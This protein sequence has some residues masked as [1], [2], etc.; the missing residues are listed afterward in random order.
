MSGIREAVSA[1]VRDLTGAKDI[2][3]YGGKSLVAEVTAMIENEIKAERE[4][5][6]LVCE[7]QATAEFG[8]DGE[9]S[10]ERCADAIRAR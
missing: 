1:L 9:W 6:A 7:A 3:C 5:C 2:T 10:A 4:A 8:C